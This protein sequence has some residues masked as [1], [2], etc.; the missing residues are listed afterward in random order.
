MTLGLQVA[1][2][3]KRS[4]GGD[5]LFQKVLGSF[6]GVVIAGFGVRGREA[7]DWG[8]GLHLAW[9]RRLGCGRGEHD[10]LRTGAG[11]K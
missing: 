4:A 2:D 1:F 6:E 7:G 9:E 8:F 10:R 5:T 3:G 11:K